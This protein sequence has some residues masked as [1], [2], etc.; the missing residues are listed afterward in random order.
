MSW[1]RSKKRFSYGGAN[2]AGGEGVET[3]GDLEKLRSLGRDLA[4]VYY[5]QRPGSAEKMT[6]LLAASPKP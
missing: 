4:P 3:A 2:M 6:K 1:K 5:W